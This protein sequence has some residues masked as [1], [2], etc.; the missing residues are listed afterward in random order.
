M[1]VWQRNAR[2][3][4]VAVAVTV[5]AAVFLTG[6]RRQ[7]PPTAPAIPRVDPSAVVD[8]SGAFVRDVKGEKERFRVESGRLLKYPDGRTKMMDVKISVERAGKSFVITGEE[9]QVGENQSSVHL[10]GKVH[11]N[12]SDGLKLDAA[13]GASYSESEGIV[14]APGPVTFSRGTM[15]GTG[16]D[17]AYDGNRDSISLADR[18][19]IQVAAD[20]KDTAGA[21]IKA[22]AA[23]LARKDH[24]MSFE[25]DVH[26]VRGDQVIDSARAIADLTD[27]EKHITALDVNGDARI[28][29]NGAV[30]GGVKAMSAS[31]IKL[32]YAE[33]SERLQRAILA[34]TSTIKIAGD[35]VVPDKTLAAESLEVAI[36]ADGTTVTA[37]N[38]QDKVSLDLP[39]PKGEP[40]K[41]IKSSRLVASGDDTHG[42]TAAVFSDGVE[43]REFGGEPAVQRLVKSRNLDAVLKNGFAEISDAR[44]TG[45]VQFN[46]GGMQAAAGEVR[47]KVSAGAVDLTGRIGNALP[48][49]ANDQVVVDSGHIEMVLDGPKMTATEGPVRTV[50]KAAKPGAGKDAAKMPGLMQQ[51][52]DVNG[53]SDKLV[54]D[55]TN[56][57]SAEFTGNARLFQAD[58]LVQG[59]K[60]AFDG[61]TGN[62]RAEGTVKSTILI[63][64]IDEATKKPTTMASTATAGSMQYEEATRKMTYETAAHLVSPQG[65]IT[66]AKIGL[67]FEQETHDVKALEGAGAVT[68]KENGRVTTGDKLLYVSQGQVYTMSGKLVKMIEANCRESTGTKLTFHKSTDLV[69][70]EG[71]GDS[72]TQSSK[73]A[74]GCV[75]RPD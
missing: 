30:S 34:G 71:N 32:S 51:D 75:P 19:S 22:G 69:D 68:L 18:T 65:D 10:T 1:Q 38:A 24:F 60:V 23:V 35:K 29:R 8:T 27:D 33:D 50:L 39:A 3:F 64:D 2:L 46:D 14:R 72:R 67:T 12:G 7:P 58:T 5:S 49:V 26:I 48:H 21:D 55:G 13:A 74:P 70:I 43:Y 17:F 41:N 20:K 9:A 63:D 25:R 37:L 66:A 45:A 44:F 6:R 15:T 61:R 31:N 54:Y 36:G 53:S 47:Y 59:Q 57:S 28:T 16:V 52:R 73:A 42:L 40:S 4:V 11:L 62:L 56:G